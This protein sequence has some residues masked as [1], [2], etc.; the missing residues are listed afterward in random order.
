[1]LD[2]VGNSSRREEG[3][4]EFRVIQGMKFKPNRTLSVFWQAL[5]RHVIWVLKSDYVHA[6]IVGGGDWRQIRKQ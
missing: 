4:V 5:H 3:D 6:S 1:M 2:M